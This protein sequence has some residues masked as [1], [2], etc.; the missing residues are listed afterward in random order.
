MTLNRVVLG[1]LSYS[2]FSWLGIVLI[3]H[4]SALCE[5]ALTNV[6]QG[7]KAILLFILTLFVMSVAATI[8]FALS[9][10]E[11]KYGY[12]DWFEANILEPL[13]NLIFL[14]LGLLLHVVII[15]SAIYF[16]G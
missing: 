3:C 6:W 14:A 9:R 12:I 13:E 2:A 10:L 15:L 11:K 16:Y 1:L 7:W 4:F 8:T 5:S